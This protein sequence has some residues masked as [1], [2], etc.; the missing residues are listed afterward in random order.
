MA[1]KLLEAPEAPSPGDQT[2]MPVGTHIRK[3]TYPPKPWLW[4]WF[5]SLLVLGVVILIIVSPIALAWL[6]SIK[7]SVNS[8]PSQGPVQILNIGR[9][10]NYAGLQYTLENA[11]YATS[12]VDDGIHSDAAVVRLNI[13][14]ANGSHDQINVIYYDIARLLAPKLS[15]ISPTNV[16]LSVGPKPGTSESGWIDF[17]VPKGLQLD[18]LKLQLGSTTLGEYLVTIPFTGKYD[19]NRYN[20]RTVAENLDINYYFPYYAPQ[21]LIYHLIS[22]DVRYAYRGNQVKA[23][24]QYYMLNFR[25]TNPNGNKLS[26]GFG[27]DYIRLS[28]NGGPP[29][30]PIDNSLPYGFDAGAKD[31]AGKVAFTG[32]AG[33][34]SIT[35]I[36]LVQYGSGGSAYDVKL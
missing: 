2:P 8:S 17:S 25:V 33:L 6:S 15:P 13:H 34:G 16:S 26:P 20:D 10:A 18:T 31:V 21:L 19:P 27:Y 9:T 35:V 7:I 14:V 28:F 29:H 32:P 3:G 22:V 11:Q 5:S 36:F 1:K 24:Q 30:P 23:G 12:F 4:L